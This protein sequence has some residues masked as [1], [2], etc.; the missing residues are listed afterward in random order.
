MLRLSF[1]S[2]LPD[3]TALQSDEN[4][5]PAV[6]LINRWYAGDVFFTFYSSGS[7]GTSKPIVLSKAFL[8]ASAQRTIQRFEIS[9]SDCLLL[10]L[11]TSFMGGMM[12]VI[13]AIVVQAELI[14][15]PP[16]ELRLSNLMALPS[17]KLA[18]LVPSQAVR[19]LEETTTDPFSNI[20]NLLLGGAPLSQSLEKRLVELKSTCHFFHTFG[21]AETASHV[22]IRK[23]T[24]NHTPYQA[25][26]GFNFSQDEKSCLVIHHIHHPTFTLATQDVVALISAQS[27]Y[28]LGRADW[29]I[30]S[31]GIKYN[32]ETAEEC[33]A[34]FFYQQRLAIP[35]TSYK[36]T[37]ETWGEKWVLLLTESLT[38]QSI[39]QLKAHCQKA[40]GKYMYPKEILLVRKIVYL[41]SGK[42]DRLKSYQEAIR[43]LI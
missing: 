22:A 16:A 3:L 15:I 12:M 27:F 30:N 5:S 37:N 41:P 7:T 1:T 33:I 14:Y 2:S 28:W 9:S 6:D 36:V 24:S 18:S 10:A 29:V 40:L 39:D 25:L 31:G 23:I 20:E 4:L 34:D 8:I 35:F 32:L 38:E 42:I 21:M 11:N 43:P 17:I 26:E 13:R 19:L